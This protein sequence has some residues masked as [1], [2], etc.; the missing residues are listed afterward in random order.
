MAPWAGT[1][2]GFILVEDTWFRL[3]IAAGMGV[4]LTQFGFLS[5]EA[6]HTGKFFASNRLNEW[7]ARLIGAGLAGIS[8]A[9]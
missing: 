5:H 6:A 1:W 8:Y 7:S 2:T 9:L 4:V 3:L